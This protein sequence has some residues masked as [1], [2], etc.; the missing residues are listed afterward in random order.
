MFHI[1]L[2]PNIDVREVAAPVANASNTDS[3]SDRIDLAGYEGV[4]F[5]CPLEDSAATGVATLKVEQNTADS[6]TGMAAL[7]GATATATCAVNDDLN[8]KLLILDV[9]KPRERYVQAVRTSATANIAF[10]TVT[11]ILYGARKLP[12]TAHTTVQASASVT[13]PAEA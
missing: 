6:D 9:F 11:A 2:L 10:G 4:I 12:V 7:A 5:V 13:S 1:P 3:N 8:G